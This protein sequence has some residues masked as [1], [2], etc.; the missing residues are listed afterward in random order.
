MTVL[1]TQEDQW[2]QKDPSTLRVTV[3]IIVHFCDNITPPYTKS[4]T[5]ITQERLVISVEAINIHVHKRTIETQ[6]KSTLQPKS[7]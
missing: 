2:I 4:K 6:Q 5:I 3:N 1:I 7:D